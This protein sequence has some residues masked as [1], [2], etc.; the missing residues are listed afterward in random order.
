MYNIE[1]YTKKKPVGYPT[2]NKIKGGIPSEGLEP[3]TSALSRL[4]STIELTR[5][6]I[7]GVP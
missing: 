5:Q 6:N 3:P 2:G 4:C 7:N 1:V